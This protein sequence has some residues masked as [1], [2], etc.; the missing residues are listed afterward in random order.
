MAMDMEMTQI[1]GF[2]LDV[3]TPPSKDSR[4]G[5]GATGLL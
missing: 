2:E 3:K 4:R 1:R 5:L